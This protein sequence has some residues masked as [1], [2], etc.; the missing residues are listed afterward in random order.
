[1]H[2]GGFGVDIQPLR[3]VVDSQSVDVAAPGSVEE[4]HK[5]GNTDVGW[6]S[7]RPVKLSVRTCHQ[8]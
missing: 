8:I 1:M 4:G 3:V 2:T 6:R 7:N 5:G